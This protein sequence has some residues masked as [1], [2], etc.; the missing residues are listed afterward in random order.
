MRKALV[1]FPVF[2]AVYPR[3][4]R[5]FLEIATVAGRMCPDWHFGF[6]APERQSLPMAMNTAAQTVL[7]QG[8]DALIA[9]DDDC[10]PP[11][12]CIPRLLAHVDTGR[13]FVAGVGVMRGYPH[14]TTV[15][16]VY[17][18]GPSLV[19]RGESMSVSGHEWLDNID[20]LPAL[21]AVDFCGVPVAVIARSALEKVAAPWFG[22]HGE[23][24][25]TVTHDV[26][27]CRKLQKA[28]IPV[29]VDTTIKC[30]HLTEPPVITF[31]NR[32]L[33]RELVGG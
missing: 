27:F 14:T 26:F 21:A 12:D 22:L 9:F 13:E 6:I 25:G 18:E 8:F 7:E 32:A 10:F 28:G 24:G 30:G 20:K 33:A 1:V 29:L 3:P 23:D 2:Q 17:E 4:F 16:R 11:Y 5:G 31:E 19:Q 15:A